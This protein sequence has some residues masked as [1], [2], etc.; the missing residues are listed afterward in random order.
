[1]PFI[2]FVSS[3]LTRSLR[4]VPNAA[5]VPRLGVPSSLLLDL[6]KP[7]VHAASGTQHTLL[8]AADDCFSNGMAVGYGRQGMDAVAILRAS[9]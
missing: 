2:G 1:M 4:W 8:V 9:K 7:Q 6:A 5:N 3:V